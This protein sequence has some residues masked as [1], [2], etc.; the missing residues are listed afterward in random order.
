MYT[1]SINGV[2]IVIESSPELFSPNSL[3]AGTAAMLSLVGEIDT[4][5]LDLG[6]GCGVVGIY[7]AKIVG[8]E[9][10]VMCDISEGAVDISR[11]NAERNGVGNVRIYHSDGF[12]NFRETGFGLILSNPPYHAD[13]S[14]P[15]HFIEES[16]NRLKPGGRLMMV[17]KRREWYENKIRS[18]FG[19][20]RVVE[21]DGYF[22][23]IAEKRAR[24]PQGKPERGLSRKL[25]RKYGGGG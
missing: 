17:T 12:R 19:G 15:K 14:V 3:D 5:V 10:V 4:P 20:V 23:F 24:K 9:N 6:C 21:R 7:A 18:V 11:K 25:E 16:R 2:D 1:A 8:E 22:V 13:F